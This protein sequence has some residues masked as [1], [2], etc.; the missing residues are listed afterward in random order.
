MKSLCNEFL[1]VSVSLKQP[2]SAKYAKIMLKNFNW[3]T[4]TLV[5]I[6]YAASD[7]AC[8]EFIFT[9]GTQVL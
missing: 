4:L 5:Y 1:Q 6:F 9:C 7:Q 3:T 8:F 2:F